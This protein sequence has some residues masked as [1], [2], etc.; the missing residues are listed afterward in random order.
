MKKSLFLRQAH[1]RPAGAARFHSALGA[2]GPRSAFMDGIAGLIELEESEV[3]ASIRGNE[4]GQVHW[5]ARDPQS[6]PDLRE[7]YALHLAAIFAGRNPVTLLHGDGRPPWAGALPTGSIN[8]P[9]SEIDQLG[10]EFLKRGRLLVHARLEQL[11]LEFFR[12]LR[13]SGVKRF[14][15]LRPTRVVE[16][17]L[18]ESLD[19]SGG[20]AALFRAALVR[21]LTTALQLRFGKKEK[22]QHRIIGRTGGEKD[23]AGCLVFENGKPLLWPGADFAEVASKGLGR[24]CRRDG[25]IYFSSS[26]GSDPLRNG[27]SYRCVLQ[28][29]WRWRILRGA[30]CLED[31]E[32]FL[33]PENLRRMG[34]AK[35]STFLRLR[36]HRGTTALAKALK[37]HPFTDRKPQGSKVLL[38]TSHLKT[39]GAERQLCNLAQHLKQIRL[40]PAVLTMERE[41]DAYLSLLTGIERDCSDVPAPAFDSWKAFLDLPAQK[42][43]AFFALPRNLQWRVWNAYTHIRISKPDVLHCFLDR[44]NVVGALAGWLADVPRVLLSIRNVRPHGAGEK[45]EWCELYRNAYA[46]L[47]KDPTLG[48]SANSQAGI[49]DYANWCGIEKERFVL[50]RNIVDL[51]HFQPMEER[52]RLEVRRSLGVSETSP[53]LVGAFRMTHEKAPLRFLEVVER[54]RTVL[55]ELSVVVCG[56]GKLADAFSAAIERKGLQRNVQY[57]GVRKD[58]GSIIGASDLLLLTS[59]M[60]GT[61]NVLLEAQAMGVPV[62]ATNVGGS[63]EAVY[64]GVSGLLRAPEDLEGLVS[65]CLV[66]LENPWQRKLFGR[67]GRTFVKHRFSAEG[68][69]GTVME[70]YGLK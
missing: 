64:D 20:F 61:S 43:E 15:L 70:F 37:A 68:A 55:P 10:T 40:A 32:P 2:M 38:F 51:A 12:C 34:A 63:A 66:L 16:I 46:L 28:R 22:L 48:L 26:D 14:F 65:A 62:V 58:I 13:S 5:R 47:A 50:A 4:P 45:Q 36:L 8:C 33:G 67:A 6:P 9:L 27:R 44:P 25:V 19:L 11:N 29:G 59:E 3:Y 69:A 18:R 49:R 21:V 57:L 39:G 42:K 31:G 7:V 23:S 56:D 24:H 41:K 17:R 53:L 1:I 52:R 35:A 30:L 54:V 60:E